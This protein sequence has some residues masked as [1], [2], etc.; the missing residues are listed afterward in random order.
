MH[1]SQFTVLARQE[2]AKGKADA[3]SRVGPAEYD[4]FLTTM[5]S[6]V[7]VETHSF[8]STLPRLTEFK[9]YS[10]AIRLTNSEY[11]VKNIP[12]RMGPVT[13]QKDDL[14]DDQAGGYLRAIQALPAAG[15]RDIGFKILSH[16]AAGTASTSTGFD[17]SVFFANSHVVG[18]GDNLDTFNAASN[19]GQTHKIIFMRTDN[20][21]VKPVFMQEREPLGGL[22]TDADTPQGLKQKEFE[23]WADTR[24]GLGYGYWWDAIHMTITD[25]PTTAECYEIIRQAINLFR[26]FQLP[27]GRDSD[28]PLYVHEGWVPSADN[29]VMLC[30]MGLSEI[31]DNALTISQ[32][33]ASTGNV[34]NVYKGKARLIPTSALN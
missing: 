10:P 18:S 19:D 17:G 6:T 33:I 31:L 15:Q 13:V 22:L 4:Q 16:L 30:N 2:F 34:D 5:P 27:K 11:Q 20:P 28:D 14:D 7:K 1:V 29:F 32:Y 26:T 24:F 12:Y 9:G 3:E 25:T 21:F 23:Y 8:M